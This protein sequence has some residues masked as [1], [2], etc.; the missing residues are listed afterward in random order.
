M[1][2]SFAICFHW[3]DHPLDSAHKHRV[4]MEAEQ[5][6]YDSSVASI[7]RS[8]PM[9]IGNDSP[10]SHEI[11]A[12]EEFDE[13][14]ALETSLSKESIA[15]LSEVLNND[16]GSSEGIV[17]FSEDLHMD[18]QRSS[19][20]YESPT[21]EPN[22]GGSAQYTVPDHFVRPRKKKITR[23]FPRKSFSAFNLFFQREMAN[24]SKDKRHKTGLGE[25]KKETAQR[26]SHL[27]RVERM[28]FE[29][30]VQR[31]Y[32]RYTDELNH[33]N[34]EGQVKLRFSSAGILQETRN[35]T[36]VCDKV[37]SD[38]IRVNASPSPPALQQTVTSSASS[39]DGISEQNEERQVL[40]RK[41]SNDTD[42]IMPSRSMSRV[43]SRQWQLQTS[44]SMLPHA[45]PF[46]DLVPVFTHFSVVGPSTVPAL[47]AGTKVT[48]PCEDAI[49]RTF[50]VEYA[51]YRMTRAQAEEYVESLIGTWMMP[52]PGPP[53]GA[54]V[55]S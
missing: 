35:V 29:R 40:P 47:R 48:L 17:P 6:H 5:E 2:S 4:S 41:V 49:V 32:T 18:M 30:M 53:P 37:P 13:N 16:E 23:D 14:W 31:D 34:N 54:T 36:L 50:C 7:M 22:R 12:G 15:Y 42:D 20:D 11:L 10:I 24:V 26:W 45:P 44:R 9:R 33:I 52:L 21:I 25:L 46:Q 3:T 8:H 28:K 39:C 51:C 27:S 43:Q 55:L 19:R 1:I 38:T